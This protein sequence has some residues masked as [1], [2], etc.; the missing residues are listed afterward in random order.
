MHR[1]SPCIVHREA[2]AVNT[3]SKHRD[4]KCCLSANDFKKQHYLR[5]EIESLQRVN[6]QRVFC[7]TVIHDHVQAVQEGGSLDDRLVVGIVQTLEAKEDTDTSLK[8]LWKRNL[9]AEPQREEGPADTETSHTKYNNKN[10]S[11]EETPWSYPGSADGNSSQP[12]WS[13]A[14]G[15]RRENILFAYD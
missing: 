14:A 8:E 15:V 5:V 4:E 9:E 11:A 1:A 3:S 13:L 6:N 7:Q 12:V 2:G 10:N